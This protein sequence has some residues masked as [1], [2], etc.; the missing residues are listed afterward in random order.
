MNSIKLESHHNGNTNTLDN[1]NISNNGSPTELISSKSLSQNMVASASALSSLNIQTNNLKTSR[2]H[3]NSI[4]PS[5]V[6]L[7][8]SREMVG[9]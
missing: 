7:I 6:P 8:L 5:C 2:E 3:V 9:I 4:S 1:N